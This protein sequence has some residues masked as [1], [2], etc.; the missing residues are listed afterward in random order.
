MENKLTAFVQLLWFPKKFS[1]D[2]RTSHLSSMIISGQ[3]TREQALD[4][5][6]EPFYTEDLMRG[7]IDSIKK[8]L[9][10]SDDEFESIMQSPPKR[11]ED[12]RTEMIMPLLRK[13]K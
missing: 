9:D 2:K 7:Y 5:L 6:S 8:Q 13:F 1:V 12:Y 4:I 11:H 10:I 3:M